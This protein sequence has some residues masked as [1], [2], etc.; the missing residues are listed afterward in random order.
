MDAEPLAPLTTLGVGGQRDGLR[1]RTIDDV[2]RAHRWNTA[3]GTPLFVLGGGSNLVIA[4]AVST[5][6]S[7]TSTF[8]AGN[9]RTKAD[10]RSSPPGRGI[11][12]ET[13][14]DCVAARS[15]WSGVPLGNSGNSRGNADPER[16]RIRPGS[17]R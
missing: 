12:D 10:L 14:A 1:A 17:S 9:M 4:D 15:G 3:N 13:V 8:E 6:W 16:R 2:E 5:D 7:C 11:W